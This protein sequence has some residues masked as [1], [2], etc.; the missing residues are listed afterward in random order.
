MIAAM[1]GLAL[2]GLTVAGQET[3]S[4]PASRP[5]ATQ[6]ATSESQAVRENG[7]DFQVV[8]PAVW[9][10][11]EGT[12]IPL[13]LKITNR[14]DHALQFNLLDT[15]TIHIK[16]VTGNELLNVQGVRLQSFMPEPLLVEKSQS[17]TIN[18]TARLTLEGNSFR[19]SG[20]DGAGGEWY[21]E[22]VKAGKHTVSI[23]YESTQAS[24]GWIG[25]V[26]TKELAVEIAN[27]PVAA[28]RPAVK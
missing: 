21:C 12:P 13:S 17:N 10:L 1:I 2:V 11:C 24:A 9:E 6:P 16:D 14:T 5:A 25:K 18:R 19:L 3:A 28:T 27:K 20:P 22:N 23:V 4:G 7:V 8:T 15:V 26:T